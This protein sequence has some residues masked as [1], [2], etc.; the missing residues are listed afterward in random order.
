[1]Q[2]TTDWSKSLRVEV[3]GDDVVGHAG[4]VIPRM[5]ADTLGLTSGLSAALSRPEVLHDR[6]AVL[7]D[8]AVAV[9]GGAENLAGTAVLRDQ[10]LV[11]GPVASIPTMWRSLNEIDHA[12][13]ARIAQVRNKI[14][15][16]VW[17]LIEARHGAIPPSRTCYGDL[18]EV[19][20]IR[21]D[22]TLT[23]C[24]SDKEGAAGNFKGGYGHHPL[25]AWC[26]DTG[27]LLAIIPRKGNAG[28]NTAADHIAIIDAAIAAIPAKW[29]RNLLITIDGAGSSHEVVAH[30]TTLNTRPGWSVAY[31]V[32]FDLDRRVRTAIAAMPAAG[33]EPAL[34]AAG[35]ARDDAQVAELTGLLREGADGDR[36]DKWPAGMRILV[37]REEV[38]EGRQLSLFEQLN[39]Y[40]YQVTATATRGGHPQRLEARHR[41]HAR[42]EGF[43]RC[44]KATGLAKWPSNSFAIN[45]AWVIA[46]AIAI[47]LLCWMRLL[48]LDG[49]LAK[50]EPTTLRYRLLHAAARVVRRSR[51]LIL[52]VPETWPWAEEFADAVDRVRAI[53]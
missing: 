45:T 18:G 10:K 53:P 30:L 8:V 48:L 25:T 46:A 44:A 9:A 24:Y 41:V 29:R 11:F 42:V 37:R 16:R 13:L 50:A 31:S 7:R 15:E 26:D 12:G 28:S 2:A 49:P 4:N 6:G 19:I 21:I 23:E 17:E 47:D 1:M 34:D 3:R 35:K 27:E 43:I 51:Y 52:R 33:W 40:R 36:L 14:R 38:E 20:V 39:G 22:A 5:L 32:G